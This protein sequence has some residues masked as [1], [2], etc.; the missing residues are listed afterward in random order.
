MVSITGTRGCVSPILAVI[1]CENQTLLV[2]SHISLLCTLEDRIG[3]FF[4]DHIDWA[5]DENSWDAGKHGSID[6]THASRPMHA[7]IAREDATGGGQSDRARAGGMMA[8]SIFAHELAQLVIILQMRPGRFFDMN[9]ALPLQLICHTP[10]A[11]NALNYGGE[12]IAAFI[13]SFLE[14]VKVDL[15]RVARIV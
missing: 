9:Q 4:A 12:I 13:G 11:A 2:V 5:R 14:I 6:Y 10:N 15:W 1:M 3:S 8:P 7:E